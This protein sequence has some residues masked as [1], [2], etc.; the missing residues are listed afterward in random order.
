MM[1]KYLTVSQLNSFIKG[2]FVDEYILHDI[3]VSGEVREFKISGNST[4]LTLYE[5]ECVLNCLKFSC[6]EKIEIGT[7][8][9]VRGGVSFFEKGGRVTFVIKEIK[10]E[11]EGENA[12]KLKKLKEKLKREGLF[13]KGLHLPSLIKKM[14]VV[15]GSAG[16]VIHD[17]LSVLKNYPVEIA[18]FTVKIQGEGASADIIRAL[19]AVEKKDYDCVLLA[20]GGGSAIDLDVFNC[21]VLSR[22]VANYS[23]PVISAIG[24]EVDYTLVDLCARTRCATPSFAAQVISDKFLAYLSL[25]Q[26]Y[27]KKL[28]FL[29]MRLYE[30]KSQT[31]KDLSNEISYTGERNLSSYIRKITMNAQI[32]T[33]I[34][35]DKLRVD[36]QK[37]VNFATSLEQLNPLKLLKRGFVKIEKEG[38]AIASVED[39]KPNDNVDIILHDGTLS[40]KIDKVNRRKA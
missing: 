33:G 17:I 15:T 38:N 11:G 32:M 10:V 22:K 5:N 35:S 1:Q 13:E 27:S 9:I 3:W 21:E 20:R 24:H 23:L 7:K 25:M 6:H 19:N 31:L 12:L 14:C 40:V 2:V 4:Y 39:V 36:E 34:I 18:V 8:V 30:K 29:I 26:S 37:A 16:V 28:S